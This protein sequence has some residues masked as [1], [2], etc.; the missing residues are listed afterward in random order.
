MVQPAPAAHVIVD[1]SGSSIAGCGGVVLLAA[2]AGLILA[3]GNGSR[4]FTVIIGLVMLVALIGLS[5][6]ILEMRRWAPLELH[7][8]NWPLEI[9][10]TTSVHVIRRAKQS[11][12]DADYTLEAELTCEES[13]RYTVGTDTRTDTETVHRDRI[14]VDGYLRNRTFEATFDVVIPHR[15]GAPSIDLGNN[16]IEW[17]LDIDVDELSRMMAKIDFTLIVAPVLDPS[18]QNIQDTPLGGAQ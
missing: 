8:S 2:L 4:M 15:R 6:A 7:F 5:W 16:K 14:N 10:S 18:H 12:P 3:I 13:A 11:V 1:D 17:K 9:G